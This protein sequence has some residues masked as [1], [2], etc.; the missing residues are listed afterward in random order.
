MYDL[1]SIMFQSLMSDLKLDVLDLGF[2]L[3][4]NLW[5][6]PFQCF[7]LYALRFSLDFGVYFEL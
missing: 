6:L 3:N 7:A 5:I 4:F 2:V 1:G